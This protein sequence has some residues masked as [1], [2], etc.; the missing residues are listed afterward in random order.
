LTIRKTNFIN[1]LMYI[2][3]V[4]AHC[5]VGPIGLNLLH[6]SAVLFIVGKS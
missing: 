1:E 5:N 3:A 2:V 6:Y 4:A